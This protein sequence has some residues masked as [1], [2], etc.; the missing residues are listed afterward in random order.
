MDMSYLDRKLLIAMP[1]LADPNFSRG[2]TLMC[3]HNAEGALGITINR[4]SEFTLMDV[5]AQLEIRCDDPAIGGLPVFDGGPVHRERGFVLH[6]PDGMWES[7]M[8]VS[9]DIMVTTSRDVLQAIAEGR[10]PEKFLVA[11]GYAGWGAGQLEDELKENAWL[12]TDAV[13]SVIFDLPVDERWSQAVSMLGIDVSSLQP[14]GGH[15]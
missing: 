1:S 13:A 2:V 12:S 4:P 7:S 5:L 10:G 9:P 6:T 8:E 3:Q 11:L 14:A 15:A